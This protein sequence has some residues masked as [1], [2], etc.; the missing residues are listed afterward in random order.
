[1]GLKQEAF[2]FGASPDVCAVERSLTLNNIACFLQRQQE[3]A[4]E[5]FSLP[6]LSS[7]DVFREKVESAE[8]VP[9]CKSTDP[10]PQG[11]TSTHLASE[12]L[13]TKSRKPVRKQTSFARTDVRS[14]N[15]SAEDPRGPSTF[16]L[17][18]PFA[19]RS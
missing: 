3:G 17:H 7:D 16:Q 9:E 6:N 18:R 12:D 2:N 13:H 8:I 5:A 10:L 4:Q 15:D 11:V 1:M 19:I 14:D